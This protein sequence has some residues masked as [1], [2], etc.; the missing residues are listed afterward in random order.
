MK[1]MGARKANAKGY[2]AQLVGIARGLSPMVTN[3]LV[4]NDHNF[5]S[6]YRS[7]RHSSDHPVMY[8]YKPSIYFIA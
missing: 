8:K 3:W 4:A 6:A 5:Q 1:V 7:L 2:H